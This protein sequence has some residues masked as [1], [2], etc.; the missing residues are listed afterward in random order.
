L[1]EQQNFEEKLIEKELN[2]RRNNKSLKR[3]RFKENAFCSFVE[4][5]KS[6][7]ICGEDNNS[8]SLWSGALRSSA[9]VL[10]F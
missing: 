1:E 6:Q 3:R 2:Q 8:A 10:K 5:L 4:I 9:V 7:Q